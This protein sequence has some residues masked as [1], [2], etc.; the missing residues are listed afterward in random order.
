MS[1]REASQWPEKANGVHPLHKIWRPGIK[2]AKRE[3]GLSRAFLNGQF[4]LRKAKIGKKLT[5][6]HCAVN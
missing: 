1:L 6:F 3:P 5:T 2:N 4:R